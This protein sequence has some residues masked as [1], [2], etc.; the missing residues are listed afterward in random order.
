M[1]A[2]T[3]SIRRQRN[4][5]E[6]YIQVNPVFKFALRPL[7]VE[8][9]PDVAKLMS[10]AARLAGVGPM[11]AV[12]GVLA[13]LAVEEMLR[14]G[15]KVA[16]VEDGGEASIATD[17]PID[18][19]LKAGDTP[20]SERVGFR[21]D[22]SMGVATS[23]GLFSHALSFG[24]ADAATIFADNA[25]IADA[26]ATAVANVVKGEARQEVIEEAI[27]LGLSIRGVRG[28]FIMFKGLVGMGGEIPTII[29]VDPHVAEFAQAGY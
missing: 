24:E 15:A 19:A 1:E 9:G 5:L 23:S 17:R 28:V 21:I 16:I 2:A 8:D 11:A 13:D 14:A 29:G 10:E 20:L 22:S 3:S 12:A 7:S 26:A 18:V 6:E 25:G 4:E 27:D